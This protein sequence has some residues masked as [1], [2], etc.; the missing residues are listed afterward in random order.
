MA[1]STSPSLVSGS[2]SSLKA[3]RSIVSAP[4]GGGLPPEPHGS[5]VNREGGPSLGICPTRSLGHGGNSAK[6]LTRLSQC[7]L[8]VFVVWCC[9]KTPYPD[10][11]GDWEWMAKAVGRSLPPYTT[12]PSTG[13]S[14]PAVAP[15]IPPPKR[16]ISMVMAVYF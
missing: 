9:L 15:W 7:G 3:W 14:T 11:S 10:A 6:S 12:T 2:S 13:C 5:T 1:V 8:C 16:R 4:P